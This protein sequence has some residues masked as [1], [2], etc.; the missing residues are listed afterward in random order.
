MRR[1]PVAPIGK[2]TG[3]V[4]KKAPPCWAG[5]GLRGISDRAR[6]T[7]S[8]TVAL[9]AVCVIITTMMVM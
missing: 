3:V 9:R 4:Y 6:C 5:Q 1:R 7:G 8:K 2:A